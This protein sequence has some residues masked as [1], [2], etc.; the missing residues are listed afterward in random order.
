[1]YRCFKSFPQYLQKPLV[2]EQK[3]F[4][5]WTESVPSGKLFPFLMYLRK[6]KSMDYTKFSH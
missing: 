1:M 3:P 5:D 6:T 2:R 4:I